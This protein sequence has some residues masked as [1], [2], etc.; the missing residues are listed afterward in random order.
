MKDLT[1]QNRAALSSEVFK[2][3]YFMDE[4]DNKKF[5]LALVNEEFLYTDDQ[6]DML[7]DDLDGEIVAK[8]IGTAQTK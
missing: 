4:L 6:L 2:E 1:H 8:G 3:A 7:L 5:L